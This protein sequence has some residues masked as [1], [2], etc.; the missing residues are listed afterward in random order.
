MQLLQAPR[1]RVLRPLTMVSGIVER[2]NTL[3]ILANVLI[4]KE[5]SRVALVASDIE[6]QITTQ[7]DAGVGEDAVLT[8]VAARKLQDILRALP[9]TSE[10][11]LTLD[12]GRLTVLAG[13]SRFALQTM[14]AEDFPAVTLPD[15]WAVSLSMAQST[16]RNLFNSVHYAMANQ[17]I[18]YYLNGLLLVFAAD[19]VRAVATDGHRLA[20]AGVSLEGLEGLAA[21]LDAIVPRKTVLEMQRLL[22]DSDDPVAIDVAGNMIRFR[23]DEIE[24]ISKLVEGKFPD[25]T[26]V[27]PAQYG[28]HLLVERE[29][30]QGSLQRAAIL[31]T[32]RQRGVRLQLADDVLTITASNT[33][34]EEA[35]EEIEVAYDGR[36]IDAGFNVTYLLDVLAN[37]RGEAVRW[38]FQAEP[39]SSVLITS[40]DDDQFKYVVMPM[41]L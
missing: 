10:V 17:D 4:R 8:T 33:E 36:A 27:I 41:R 38:S 14:D 6:V 20:H 39:N 28:S 19:G 30:L 3:P 7:V 18:R 29:R 1:D 12:Q 25:F 22:D 13:K 24:L 35:R 15:E 9:D 40:P 32:D 31:T 34:Q 23:F 21:P 2:R 11:S 5:A 16:L 37:L 26:R